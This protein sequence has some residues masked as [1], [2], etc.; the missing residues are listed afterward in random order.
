MLMAVAAALSVLAEAANAGSEQ[1]RTWYVDQ[2]G[3]ASG[4]GRSWKT[5]LRSLQEGL[6]A[7]AKGDQIWV[8]AGTYYPDA[9]DV[10]K[11]FVLKEDVALY[12]GF[13]GRETSREQRD[14][15]KHLTILSG[16]IGKG[17]RTRNS[18]T[19]VVGADRAILDG[20][21]VS[22]AYATDTARMHLV[23]ADILKGNMVAGG[24][25]RNFMTA[26][27]V[28]NTVFRHNYSPKGGAVYNV[29]KPGA[30]QAV[31]IN[32][33][34]IDN[35]AEMRG[36]G[37]SNDLG[38]M[39]H[40]INCRFIGNRSLDKGGALYNDFAA[41][42]LVFNSLFTHNSAVTA[43]AIGNDGGSAPLLVNVTIADNKAGSGLGPGL[44][45]GT[46]ANSNPI[47]VNSVV[48]EVYNWHEDVVSEVGSLAPRGKT[49]AL[50]AFL[51]I[52]SLK[53]Q[54][55]PDDLKSAPKYGRGYRPGLDGSVLLK[56][57]LIE[58]LIRFYEK[59]DGA[60]EYR[61]EYVR[62]NVTRQPVS[63]ST[64]YVVPNSSAKQRDGLSWATALTD[65]QAAIEIASVS[66]AAV[67]IKAGTYRPAKRDDRIAAFILYDGVKLHGG[68]AGTETALD[69]RRAS[70][71]RT[72]LSAR[73]ATGGYRFPHVLY[74]A[75]DVLLDSLT[76]RDG[77]ATG[78]TYDGKGG[79]L[80]AYRAG[81]KFLPRESAV[82]FT[83][84]IQN[85]RFEA[86]VALEGGAIY[87][88]G[89]AALTVTDTVFAGNRA[90]FGGAVVDR[91]GTKSTFRQ[92]SFVG[93]Q[94][95]QNG[96]AT[97]EDYGS[98]V[99]FERATFERN[100]ARYQGGAMYVL[101][102]ASQ[103]EATV[104]SVDR[105]RFSLNRA[106]TGASIYNLDDSTLTIKDSRYPAGS[107]HNPA[108]A[109]Q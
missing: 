90:Q 93:N 100:Q 61:G 4:D 53:G 6:S 87:A 37:V 47:L 14:F 92:S 52:S 91:E 1:G 13:S 103:L 49:L 57:S 64:I 107:V 81:K 56:N 83:M 11:S 104:V 99:A 77:Q 46:G 48:D 89:K 72:V 44:Y 24:G 43:G 101:S 67:W 108:A 31:F 80:L 88:F 41:S 78:F 65:L 25:M 8:A 3:P 74:G 39:P 98:H 20:F 59:N 58:K 29:H 106:R 19:V 63:A 23:P 10:S 51:A 86:N 30:D 55:Q 85:C 33:D 96:G 79:G 60:V 18:R 97:Y 7:A 66:K 38:A 17:D 62:P 54:L 71:R 76:V 26:P 69:Q 28:R 12:G 22:D 5:A 95:A 84:T 9:G 70:G 50:G 109:K 68:F 36:G 45:Q 75:D 40:F 105:S 2:N 15:R 82:G 42:P 21:T 27:T 16:N 94:A 34:F 32:V 35:V 102:R 73:T